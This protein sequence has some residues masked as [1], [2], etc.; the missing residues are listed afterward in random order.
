MPARGHRGFPPSRSAAY[1]G[2]LALPVKP[3]S[4]RAPAAGRLEI[5]SDGHALCPHQRRRTKPHNQRASWGKTRGSEAAKDEKKKS[6]NSITRAA[7]GFGKGEV[8]SSILTGSTRKCRCLLRLC[9]RPQNLA[10]QFQ[11]ER[12]ANKTFRC[13]EKAW[14]L[15]TGVPRFIWH[16]PPMRLRA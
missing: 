8:V 11:A 16:M 12:Y 7:Y 9:A 4:R 1:L 15:F 5:G 6:I 3:R 10:R 2:D 14:T 13:V